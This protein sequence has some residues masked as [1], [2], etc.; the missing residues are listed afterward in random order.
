MIATALTVGHL[1]LLISTNPIHIGI[2]SHNVTS[3][4]IALSSQVLPRHASPCHNLMIVIVVSAQNTGEVEPEGRNKTWHNISIINGYRHHG[5]YFRNLILN[6]KAN[7]VINS[8]YKIAR[9]EKISRK[10]F[11]ILMNFWHFG[12]F[13]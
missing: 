10:I 7:F 11:L 1:R 9:W 3:S 13:L 6:E 8:S 4:N 12:I 5:G 2:S